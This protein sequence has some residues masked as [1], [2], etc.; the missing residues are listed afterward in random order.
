MSVIPVLRTPRQL[1]QAPGQPVLRT[2]SLFQKIFKAAVTIC[3]E[4]DFE[5]SHSMIKQIIVQKIFFSLTF[6][7]EDQVNVTCH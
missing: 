4:L 6:K 2:E 1:Q 3:P 7:N 5:R